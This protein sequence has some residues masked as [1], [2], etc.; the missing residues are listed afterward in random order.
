MQR[1]KKDVWKQIKVQQPKTAT[2][3]NL[4]WF[5]GLKLSPEADINGYYRQTA[6]SS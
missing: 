3:N 2:C 1:D 6:L 4:K 5:K